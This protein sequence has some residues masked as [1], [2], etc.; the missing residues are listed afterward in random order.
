MFLLT[1]PS[2]NLLD[3]M[4]SEGETLLE[5][6]TI[7]VQDAI[8]DGGLLEIDVEIEKLGLDD[9]SLISVF[10]TKETESFLEESYPGIS[11]YTVL[12]SNVP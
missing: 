2:N 5:K 11:V 10:Y 8:F 1:S 9:G 3:P 7:Q 4:Q 12:F 6:K